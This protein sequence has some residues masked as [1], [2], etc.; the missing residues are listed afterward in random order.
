MFWWD[1]VGKY[2]HHDDDDDDDNDNSNNIDND[3][4]D[5][6]DGKYTQTLKLSLSL[7]MDVQQYRIMS[8]R[9]ERLFICISTA[10]EALNILL[11]SH[12]NE[13][14]RE[15]GKWNENVNNIEK[16]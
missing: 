6:D 9:Y 1:T 13:I 15:K 16:K 14:T 5:D 11:H 7:Y 2:K 3:E 4:N 8:H 10:D 12:D